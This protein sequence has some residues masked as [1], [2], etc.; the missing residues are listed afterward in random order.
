MHV[1]ATPLKTVQAN[2]SSGDLKNAFSNIPLSILALRR[3]A[4]GLRLLSVATTTNPPGCVTRNNSLRAH[5]AFSMNS[6]AVTE[7]VLS[8]QPSRNGRHSIS[9]Q[10]TKN[11]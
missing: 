1:L 11:G 4:Q 10:T 3:V 8:K 9:P 7:T 2:N 5:L 6:R